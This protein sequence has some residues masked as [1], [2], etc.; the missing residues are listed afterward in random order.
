MCRLFQLLTGAVI[1]G[2]T[3]VATWTESAM[4]AM[5]TSA[6]PVT[7]RKDLSRRIRSVWV[8][9]NWSLPL[10]GVYSYVF[11]FT[12]VISIKKK[13]I[14][15]HLQEGNLILLIMSPT[16]NHITSLVIFCIF[17][18]L[19]RILPFFSLYFSFFVFFLSLILSS[20]VIPV[21]FSRFYERS[22]AFDPAVALSTW[23]PFFLFFI[24]PYKDG[25]G[26]G[27]GYI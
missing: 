21:S 11:S 1:M 17:L 22:H 2:C 5:S 7:V 4:M 3:S 13:F 16:V 8:S 12:L 27:E 19:F 18:S 6:I 10:S 23:S 9:S 15:R 25:G 24:P 26:G 14:V 20:I